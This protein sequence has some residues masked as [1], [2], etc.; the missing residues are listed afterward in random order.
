MEDN[1]S[2]RPIVFGKKEMLKRKQTDIHGQ[3]KHNNSSMNSRYLHF[4]HVRDAYSCLLL[5]LDSLQSKH[6]ID[7]CLCCL[8]LQLCKAFSLSV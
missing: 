8:C 2:R 3:H 1:K 5:E 7:S 4:I 6:S